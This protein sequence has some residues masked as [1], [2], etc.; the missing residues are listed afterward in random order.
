MDKECFID[1]D[2]NI[3]NQQVHLKVSNTILPNNTT[4]KGMGT[5]IKNVQK[6]LDLQYKNKHK[7]LI[8]NDLDFFKIDLQID[9]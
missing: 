5:G 8:N 2:L 4:K 9:L 3:E 1:I 7:L 6:R